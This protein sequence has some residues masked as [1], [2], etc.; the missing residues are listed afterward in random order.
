MPACLPV[1]AMSLSQQSDS[2]PTITSVQWLPPPTVPLAEACHATCSVKYGVCIGG[3]S[4]PQCWLLKCDQTRLCCAVLCAAQEA[5]AVEEGCPPAGCC[6]EMEALL[7]GGGVSSGGLAGLVAAHEDLVGR[8]APSHAGM[9]A[10]VQSHTFCMQPR[11]IS[12]AR[13]M[14][15]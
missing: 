6:A 2:P 12:C 15:I 8:C 7:A 11:A 3:Q 13:G 9:Q 1:A 10:A 5:Q 14:V 4:L